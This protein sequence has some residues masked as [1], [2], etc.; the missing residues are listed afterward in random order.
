MKF[1]VDK[2]PISSGDC[3]FSKWHPFP[4]ICE[5]P[6]YYECSLTKKW[7]NL[8]EIECDLLKGNNIYKD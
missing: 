7:C 3:L 6:G 5:T 1:I 8:T 4:P 2:M